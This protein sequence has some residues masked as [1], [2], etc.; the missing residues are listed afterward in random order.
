MVTPSQVEREILVD[1]LALLDATFIPFR[2]T[3]NAA[4][5][6]VYERRD[7]YPLTGL[8]FT[9]GGGGKQRAEFSEAM[10]NLKAGGLIIVGGR[11]QG[12]NLRFTPK[13]EWYA[14]EYARTHTI[15]ETWSLLLLLQKMGGE[16]RSILENYIL[17]NLADYTSAEA[18][19]LEEFAIPL[20]SAGLVRTCADRRGSVGWSV[21]PAGTAAIKAGCPTDPAALDF[22]E[23]LADRYTATRRGYL[24]ERKTWQPSR[25]TDVFIPLSAGGWEEPP[26]T[27]AI[28]RMRKAFQQRLR[29]NLAST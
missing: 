22:D 16:E 1:L 27:I 3:D 9:G 15:E 8:P 24:E 20:L 17:G 11:T 7:K 4:L 26:K 12:V 21:T 2:S 13:G 18:V 25:K 10:S 29:G 14:R 23:G 28:S 5:V 19:D 6:A